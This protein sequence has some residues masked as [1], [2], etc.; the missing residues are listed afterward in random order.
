MDPLL[1]WARIWAA[2]AIVAFAGAKLAS[3]SVA[4]RAMWWPRSSL[5][6]VSLAVVAGLAEVS[7][8]LLVVLSLLPARAIAIVSVLCFSAFTAYG[9]VGI[10]LWGSCGCAGLA[11]GPSTVAGFCARNV[12]LFGATCAGAAFGPSVGD[13]V[14]SPA[15]LLSA[16]L[17]PIAAVAV[18]LLVFSARR[19][20]SSTGLSY[21]KL[22]QRIH[23]VSQSFQ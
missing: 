19:V 15:L 2:A 14:R 12:L 1:L 21:V 6:R 3:P 10:R 4:A 22:L 17:A 5:M 23:A 16:A 13:L 11:K 8:S 7:Y 20:Q 18:G 9:V